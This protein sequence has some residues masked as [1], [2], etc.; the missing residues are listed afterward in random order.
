VG[1]VEDI[2]SGQ[3]NTFSGTDLQNL[4]TPEIANTLTAGVVYQPNFISFL[5]NTSISLD[6]YDI[7]IEDTIG[8]LSPDDVLDQCYILGDAAACALIV[9]VG[10]TLTLPGSGI[11][12]FT[13]NLINQRAEGIELAINTEFDFETLGLSPAFGSLQISFTGNK[14]LTNEYVASQAGGVIDCNGLFTRDT[15]CGTPLPQ[16]RHAQRTIW[17]LGDLSLSYL[18]R[19]LGELKAS[20][21]T[22]F[23]AFRQIE[24]YDYVDLAATYDL[25]DA[26]RFTVGVANVFDED[27][28]VVGN[29]AGTTAANSGNTFPAVY[30]VLG[31]VFSVGVNLR[32]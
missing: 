5:N 27:P 12:T 23:P 29:E 3:V 14:Y 25:T 13:T 15:T 19:H 30:D 20:D 10:G 21:Q 32:F 9:R 22:I 11:Q 26:V 17:D 6:Y 4:P 16:Y 2:V 24:A 31:R 8:A 1:T 7:D 28:P 18:W